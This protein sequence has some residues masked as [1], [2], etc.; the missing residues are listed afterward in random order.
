MCTT[1]SK[2][3]FLMRW[4]HD[5]GC[6]HLSRGLSEN[7]N[8]LN[9]TVFHFLSYYPSLLN[10]FSVGG[11]EGTLYC[12]GQDVGRPDVDKFF[13]WEGQVLKPL[14]GRQVSSWGRKWRMLSPIGWISSVLLIYTQGYYA[15]ALI[16][17]LQLNLP[18]T[19]PSFRARTFL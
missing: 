17:P 4:S 12:V 18:R 6:C 13:L 5:S 7:G 11:R 19:L 15:A 16:W 8:Q 2:L 1:L 10:K 9:P 3:H 14:K